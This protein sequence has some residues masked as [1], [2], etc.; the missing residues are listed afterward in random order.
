MEVQPASVA[1]R[2]HV[3][4]DRIVFFLLPGAV[5]AALMLSPY[6]GGDMDP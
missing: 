6:S 1:I 2:R 4:S 5:T 3:A